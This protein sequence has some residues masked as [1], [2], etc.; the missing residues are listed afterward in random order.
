[1]LL[2]CRTPLRIFP[3]LRS[4]TTFG[5]CERLPTCL[6]RPQSLHDSSMSCPSAQAP[7]AL[8][9]LEPHVST[10]F[11]Q[12]EATRATSGLFKPFYSG[13]PK[14]APIPQGTTYS[15]ADEFSPAHS[16][17]RSCNVPPSEIA[18]VS[19]VKDTVNCTDAE[20]SAESMSA[21]RRRIRLMDT[22]L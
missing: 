9:P 1:M 14:P 21:E 11:E 20:L 7:C 2:P 10:T 15:S 13:F 3:L 17:T 19:E 16:L 22:V 5:S 4:A 8:E 12:D 18:C 6:D